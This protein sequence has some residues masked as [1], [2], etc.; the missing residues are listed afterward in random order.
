M[1]LQARTAIEALRA[2]VPNGAA[3]Q[4]LGA[5]DTGMESA[6]RALLDSAGAEHGIGLAGGFGTGK[7]HTLTALGEVAR[8]Q[9][10]VV[11]R[12]VISKET[13]L[14]DVGRV[15]EAAMRR[16]A[17]P[18]RND[19]ALSAVLG[20]LRAAPGKLEA[21]QEAV[22]Q[23][24]SGLAGIFA[25][26][27]FLLRQPSLTPE[28]ARRCE[29]F[30]AGGKMPGSVFRKPLIALHASRKFN[31]RLPSAAELAMQRVRFVSQLFRAAGYAGWCLL[32]D[33]VELIGRY[34]PMQRGL[35]YASLA[36]WLGLDDAA[37]FSGIA[38]VY[39]ITDDFV[40]A[41]IEHRHDEDKLPERLR[42]KG[43]DTEAMRA[44]TAIRHI[45]DTVQTHRLAVPDAED[46]ARDARRLRE[47]Y[48]AA[49]D[50]NAPELPEVERTAT[51]TMRQYIKAWI[52]QWDMLRV[53]G[54]A[55]LVVE[56]P[57]SSNYEVDE[58][59][60]VTEGEAGD[61]PR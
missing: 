59:L 24:D 21:L 15:F 5:G 45:K 34:S 8:G 13:P 51:R 11:S 37:R 56:Q 44:L 33:E 53:V 41:V 35:A 16:A 54:Q 27:V 28:V 22:G 2:G 31:L 48:S 26:I 1:N 25:A 30:L 6:F 4:L 46:L 39:A 38:V 58:G 57:L 60:G 3:V 20:A 14:G 7:S 32:F 9:R 19:D 12:V 42:L 61:P 43:R 10:F 17:L 18:D 23:A 36:V 29:R 49:Y 40:T 50:W 47:I 52:T 55:V